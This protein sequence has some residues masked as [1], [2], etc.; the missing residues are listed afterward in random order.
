MIYFRNYDRFSEPFMFKRKQVIFSKW[1][2]REGNVLMTQR[3]TVSCCRGDNS[4]RL[5]M[6]TMILTGS[7]SPSGK[8]PLLLLFLSSLQYVFA[9]PEKL[10]SLL[11]IAYVSRRRQRTQ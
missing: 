5:L 7:V 1:K 6:F 4:S 3:N 9:G 10:P 11:S 2:G 8:C